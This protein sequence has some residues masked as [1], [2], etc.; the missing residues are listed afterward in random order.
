MNNAATR[1]SASLED[2]S[3]K[4]SDPC[5]REKTGAHPVCI[6]ELAHELRQPLS[7]IESLAYYL[8]ITAL[9]EHSC[10]QYQKIRLMVDRASRILD[11]AIA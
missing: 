8:E 1:V 4:N 10:H 6:G 5:D 11:R 7:T 2:F 9:D 3:L